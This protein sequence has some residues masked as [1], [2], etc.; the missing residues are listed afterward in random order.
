MNAVRNWLEATS[1][2]QYADAL[3]ANDVEAELINRIERP[4]A[5]PSTAFDEHGTRTRSH[6]RA[7]NP[8]PR[9]NRGKVPR[10]NADA[11]EKGSVAVASHQLLGRRDIAAAEHR[12]RDAP[13]EAGTG[14]G[15]Q[16]A[17]R[18]GDAAPPGP[19][20]PAPGKSAGGAEVE[21]VGLGVEL[22]HGVGGDR[23]VHALGD[24]PQT[25]P[26]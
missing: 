1:L 22:G 6:S 17:R 14:K 15:G 21:I 5:A 23:R 24:Q 3:E 16:L 2:G 8:P 9:S 25:N 19:K 4:S 12:L 11:P 13:A 10:P 20:P 7:L 26:R 18:R